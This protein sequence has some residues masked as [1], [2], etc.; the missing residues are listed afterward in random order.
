ME[1]AEQIAIAPQY[2][3]TISLFDEQFSIAKFTN[4][5]EKTEAESSDI[6]EA[7]RAAVCRAYEKAMGSDDPKYIVQFDD[8]TKKALKNGTVELV[9]KKDG[10]VYAQIR[11]SQTKKLKNNLSIKEELSV[12]GIDSTQ[13]QLALQMEEI[14]AQLEEIIQGIREIE[15][16]VSQIAQGQR[17]D[18]IGLFFSGLS[19]YV[20]AKSITDKYLQ[21][22][23]FAQAL[24][25]ISDA[26][27]QMIQ[28][29]R[30][31]IEYLMA[32]E[33]KKHKK[34][35]EKI[36][37]HLDNI[38]Q[39]YDVVYRS[40][41]LKATIYQENGETAAMLTSIDEYSRFI[42]QMIVPYVGRL[43]ELDKTSQLIDAGTWGQIANTLSGCR[44][45]RQKIIE[46]KTYFLEMGDLVHDERQES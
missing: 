27:A 23:M 17:N 5:I 20:E 4:A 15:G 14:K 45:L 32:G 6:L 42:E 31:N 28:D 44:E 19:L 12:E 22:Q 36:D 18:R 9:P 29:I 30:T 37:E 41:F 8:E 13:L 24:R 7:T 21:K 10:T 33:Y 40:A 1:K 43:S 46:D 11:D 2:D 16:R 25:S 38:R 35:S 26:N 3:G 39:C 34:A